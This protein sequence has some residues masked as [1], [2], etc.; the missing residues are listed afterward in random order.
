M[1]S[2]GN[3][4]KLSPSSFPDV[5]EFMIC[6]VARSIQDLSYLSCHKCDAVKAQ[7]SQP[8]NVGRYRSGKS[9]CHRLT[10]YR[11]EKRLYEARL[12]G[13]YNLIVRR[14]PSL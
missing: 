4:I 1:Y 2:A 9:Q 11:R 8:R 10:L 12:E 13:K 5:A 3:S 7:Q 6:L 14:A